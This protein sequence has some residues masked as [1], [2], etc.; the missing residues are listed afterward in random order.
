MG[1]DHP[2]T[3]LTTYLNEPN[4]HGICTNAG[5]NFIQNVPPR[6]EYGYCPN[7]VRYTVQSILV[8]AGI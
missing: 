2:L 8:L 6:E 5:C 3:L 7:C 4:V 1:F